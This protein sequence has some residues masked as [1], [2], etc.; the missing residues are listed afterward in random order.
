MNFPCRKECGEM[1]YWIIGGS[2]FA[3]ILSFLL[4]NVV[5]Q[6]SELLNMPG[7]SRGKRFFEQKGM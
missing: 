5:E 3:K 4:A 7:A 1:E 2:A 6:L